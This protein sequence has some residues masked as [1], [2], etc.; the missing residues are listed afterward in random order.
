M[1]N[2][3][4]TN[5]KPQVSGYVRRIIDSKPYFL[6]RIVYEIFYGNRPKGFVVHHMCRNKTCVNPRHLKLMTI[7]EHGKYHR[8]HDVHPNNMITHCPEGHAY[9][10]ENTYHYKT[11]RHCRKCRKETHK[12]W[13]KQNG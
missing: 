4:F 5:L 7:S 6:H 11:H 3:I 12:R 8:K 10:E 2:C 13:I 1:T 9:D